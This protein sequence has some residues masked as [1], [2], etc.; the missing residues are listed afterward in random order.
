MKMTKRIYFIAAALLF[1]TPLPP[2]SAAGLG[3]QADP[4]WPSPVHDD[5]AYGMVLFDR[6]EWQSIDG[7]DQLVWDAQ[8]WY[9]KDRD[10]LWVETEGSYNDQHA[11]ELENLDVQY[12]RRISAFWDLQ[13]GL[14]TQSTFGA[15]EKHERYYGIVGFQGLAPYWFEIDTNLRLSNDGDAW[16]D[17]EAEYDWRLTQKWILQARA[18]TSYA[19]NE[20]VAFEQGKGFSGLTGGFRLRYHFSREFAPYVGITH[21]RAIGDTRDL[22]RAEGEDADTTSFVAG[23]LFWF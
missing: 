19:F 14:G 7:L 6:F 5:H 21:N 23:F 8:G 9:G 2:L 18:E 4:S 3:L 12:S 22:I 20:A 17:F 10:R 1:I 16:L 15:S 11:G 13:I